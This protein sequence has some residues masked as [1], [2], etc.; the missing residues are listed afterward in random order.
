MQDSGGKMPASPVME[1]VSEEEEGKKMRGGCM[2]GRKSV[3]TFRSGK[4]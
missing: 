4:Q 3:M 2:G 1:G